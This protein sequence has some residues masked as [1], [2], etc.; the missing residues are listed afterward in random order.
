M[1]YHFVNNNIMESLINLIII[2]DSQ[3]YFYPNQE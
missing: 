3:I 2:V 1:L